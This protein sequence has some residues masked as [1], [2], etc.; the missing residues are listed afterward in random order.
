MF[1]AA[2]GLYIVALS[3]GY[4]SLWLQASHCSGFSCGAQVPD[5]PAPVVEAQGLISCSSWAPECEGS[6]SCDAWA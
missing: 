4:S 2:H 6:G 3:G 5:A 1:T